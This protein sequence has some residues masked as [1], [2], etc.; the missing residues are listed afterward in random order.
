MA[1]VTKIN[2]GGI[3]YDI[4]HEGEL[5]KSGF[6]VVTSLPT[7]DLFEGRMVT[8]NNSIYFYDGSHWI[9]ITEDT[10][11]S[12][13]AS[14]GNYIDLNGLPEHLN[15]YNIAD[16]D[17][18]GSVEESIHH[19]GLH[20]GVIAK[21]NNKTFYPTIDISDEGTISWDFSTLSTT[22]KL[23]LLIIG[24]S[25]D[26]GTDAYDTLQSQINHNTL[27]INN[28]KS[29]LPSGPSIVEI[30]EEL[31]SYGIEKDLRI[32]LSSCTRVGNPALHRTLPVQSGMR[33]CLLDDDG[34]I[35]EYLPQNDWTTATRDGSRGQ[36]MVLIPGH[37][38]KFY[39]KDEG[40]I[41]GVRISLNNIEG[42]HY[43]PDMFVSAYE[44]SIER[45]SGKLCS[46]VNYDANYRG[47][48][49]KTEW[50]QTY[51]SLLGRPV[52]SMNR[53]Q[54]R[55]AARKRNTGNTSWNCYLYNVHKALFWLYVVEYAN[56]NSQ[57]PYTSELTSEGFRQGGLGKGVTNWEASG[58][59]N[60]NNNNPFVPCGHTDTLGNNTGV[61]AYTAYKEDGSELKTSN[62]PRYRGVEN[63][64]GHILKIADGINVRIS[65][66]EANG[67]DNLSKVFVCEDPSK[68][69][70]TNYNGYKYV[71]NEARSEGYIKEII[72]GEEGEII[73]SLIGGGS[74]LFFCDYH[75]TS[76]QTTESL[77]AVWFGGFARNHT[78]AGFVISYT[79][80]TATTAD[81]G[82][83]SR[84]CFFPQQNKN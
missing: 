42:Y 74:T 62:V 84:L 14:T 56:L 65:P 81:S 3:N 72:F 25:L 34:N 73:P 76:I 2:V 28:L 29:G 41:I 22:D 46:V 15:F 9:K 71:G 8:W 77:R 31:Y 32:S 36:V 50:D 43:V 17:K 30:E 40:N 21:L 13:V 51:R 66:T 58:W 52:T 24:S 68:F 33:G 78:F 20:P 61:V 35:V 53:I 70:D 82:A 4:A 47:G 44:A 69:N 11:L 23:S 55:S 80:G 19:C 37:Y 45:S 48:T 26:K 59:S 1:R 67:G 75:Y 64:F 38:R 6:E 60:F 79:L 83:G 18:S 5:K 54:F 57:L 12:L 10:E 7:T 49:N 27:E 16:A 39:T 63:P